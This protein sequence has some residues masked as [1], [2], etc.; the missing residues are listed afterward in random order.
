[1][2]NTIKMG[3]ATRCFY[4]LN[5]IL[6][7][8]I[9][10][11]M[12]YPVYYVIM[13]SLCAPEQL[14]QHTGALFWPLDA[15][16]ESYR[17]AFKNPMLLR[18]YGNTI[19][20]V[21]VGVVVNLLLT[22]IGAYFL[23]RKNVRLQ[24]PIYIAII[25][26]MFFSGGMIPFYFAVK[27][28]GLDGSLWALIFPS[29]ITTFTLI[30]M[31][32]S[33]A[34]I[35]DSLEESARMDGA[36]HLT[37]LFRIVLPVS[38]ATLAVICLYYAVSHWNAWFHAMLFLNDREKYPL[39]LI[40]RE[41]LIQNDTSSMVT[42]SAEQGYIGETIKYAVIVIATVPILCIYPFLQKYFAKGVMIGAVKG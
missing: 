40:L 19:F 34:S 1:M 8:I 14:M 35:P 6:M 4:S 25:I 2:R 16:L 3:A 32:V 31:R 12:V 15:N 38:K 20:V 28:L 33:F 27:N 13:A 24:K 21:V 23:S 42:E 9:A 10:V 26:T 30:I 7:L 17:L 5:S 29:A 22:S 11:I 37:M 39:Q 36:G 18:G 41:I